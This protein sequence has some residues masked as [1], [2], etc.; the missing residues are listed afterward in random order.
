[1]RQRGGAWGRDKRDT[2]FYRSIYRVRMRSAYGA[3]HASY[4]LGNFWD[5][6]STADIANKY[7]RV[8]C[9]EHYR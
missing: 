2:S 1:M 4:R 8:P 9:C 3:S 5:D 6:V 7:C